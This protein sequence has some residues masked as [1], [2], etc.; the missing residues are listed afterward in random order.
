MELAVLQHQY[1]LIDLAIHHIQHNRRKKRRRK[2]RGIWMRSWIGRRRQFGMYDQLLVEL[3]N[4][5]QQC[6]KNFMR[7][8]PEM[9]DELLAR[10][11]PR[12]TKQHTWY[13]QPLEPGLKLALTLRHLAS[14]STYS[15]MKYGW[16]VPHNTQSLIVREV[17]QAIIDEYMPDVMTCP[18]TPERWRAISDKFLKRWNFP[19][20]CGAL[21]GKHIACK[22]PPKSGSQYFNY[23]GFYS[24]V[25]MDLVDA[26]YKF[27]WADIGGKGSAS[28]AQIYNNS[29]IKEFAEDGT[30]GFPAPDALPNDYQNVPY[31]FI[32][33]DAFALRETMMKPYSLRGLDNEER[34]FNYRLSRARRV[35]E[36]AFGILAN[37][38]QVMLTTMQHH[39]STVKL[40][41]KAC[42]V[43]HNLMRLR[44][45]ELQ[46]QHLDRAENMNSDFI[47]G[48]WRQD[49]NLH[50]THTVAGGNTSTNKGKKQRN[51]L[52]HWVN[53]D[54]G[55]VPWQDK[56]I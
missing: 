20:T 53:S 54:A 34:I 17:C 24:V 40:I 50:D 31:F 7:M 43:L 1:D 38:F 12:T 23:K 14:G 3:R 46:N 49:R 18:T 26:D 45:P 35:V 29:E 47:P 15:A 32:G 27:I 55:A 10:V 39:P 6:F 9:F 37:R 11:S 33:D 2:R 48:A 16:R 30:I 52:K 19:H 36:N 41:V 44:Y 25:L 42:I 21:D 51:L 4:E 22:C 28:D 13:R 5:D 56:M 8:A